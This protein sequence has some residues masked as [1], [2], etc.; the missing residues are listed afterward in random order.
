MKSSPRK[1]Q[2]G[3]VAIEFAAV[4]IIFFAVFYG[5]ISYS[6]PLLLNQSFNAATAEAVRRAV[7]VDPNSTGSGYGAA[8][9]NM[10]LTTLSQKL[11]WI[12]PAFNF[13]LGTDASAVYTGGILTVRISYATSKINQVIPFLVLPVIGTLP[14]LPTTLSATSSIQ[15]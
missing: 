13:N 6:V 15:F 2:K 14:N 12:P 7:S 3:A 8:V 10:A 11:Q 9:Q 1:K 4:F 5:M